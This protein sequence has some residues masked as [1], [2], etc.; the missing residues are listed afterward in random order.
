[1]ISMLIFTDLCQDTSTHIYKKN[2][3][4]EAI[5]IEGHICLIL[6][7]IPEDNCRKV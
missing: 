4:E 2:S 7:N 5:L 1:M 3:F 6:L